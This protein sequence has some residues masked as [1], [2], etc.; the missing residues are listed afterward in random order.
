[1][2]KEPHLPTNNQKKFRWRGYEG[3]FVIPIPIAQLKKSSCMCFLCH[4]CLTCSMCFLCHMSSKCFL[5]YMCLMWSMCFLCHMC[6]MSFLCHICALRV[7]CALCAICTNTYSMCFVVY[8]FYVLFVPYVFSVFLCHMC[9]MWSMWLGLWIIVL[10]YVLSHKI[11][12]N[13]SNF[14][15]IFMKIIHFNQTQQRYS[16]LL[17]DYRTVLLF[18]W[19]I[20]D[21]DTSALKEI[22]QYSSLVK[23]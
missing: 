3:L 2:L 9:L 18:S 15:Q 6:W 22:F 5:C 12:K 23:K 19:P 7:L 20:R 1:M 4:K 8:V 17:W 14:F 13:T 11:W 10:S 21:S 16:S